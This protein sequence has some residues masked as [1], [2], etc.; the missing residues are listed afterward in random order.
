[1]RIESTPSSAVP[2]SRIWHDDSS[3]VV[4]LAFAAHEITVPLNVPVAV[5]DTFRPPAH[6]AL[7]DPFADVAVCSDGVH[8]KSVHED[9]AGMTLA[10]ADAHVP[11]SDDTLVEVGVRV[12]LLSKLMQPLSAA[13]ETMIAKT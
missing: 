9:G 3:A 2:A 6:V 7:N 5:P 8:L 11:I 13:T 4:A 1:M 10:L 12:L